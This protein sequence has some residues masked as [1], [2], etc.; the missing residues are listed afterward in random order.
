MDDN[1]D[2]A[3]IIAS[4]YNNIEVALKLINNGA[5]VDIQ[6]K[7]GSTALILASL[8]GYKDFVKILLEDG[9]AKTDIQ[10][11][12]GNTALDVAGIL[13]NPSSDIIKDMIERYDVFYKSKNV[14][15]SKKFKGYCLDLEE[16]FLHVNG[17]CFDLDFSDKLRVKDWRV[18]LN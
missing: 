12:D 15:N 5:D 2:T 4:H 14:L 9:H 1:G 13:L 8:Y 18:Y 7:F 3:L 6:D 16:G 11:E 17:G 10:D